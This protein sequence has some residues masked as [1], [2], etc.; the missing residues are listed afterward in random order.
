MV[1]LIKQVNNGV[2]LTTSNLRFPANL[3]FGRQRQKSSKLKASTLIEV[4]VASVL[5][6]T[7]FTIASLTLNN[8][9]KSTIKS[10]THTIDTQ[11]NK[12]IYLFQHD[13]IGVKYQEDFKDWHISF[14]QQT[15]NN[16]IFIV[17][18]ATQNSNNSLPLGEI[19]DLTRPTRVKSSSQASEGQRREKRTISKKNEK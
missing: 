12:L 8:I 6:I 2:S 19:K 9:F 13:K 14:S 4:L 5:I 7:V 10:N 3:P 1:V 18:T 11:L 15:E 17:A 16:I